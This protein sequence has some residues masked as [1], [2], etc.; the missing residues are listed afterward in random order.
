MALNLDGWVLRPARMAS[1]NFSSTG[2]ITSGVSRDTITPAEISGLGYTSVPTGAVEPWA[3]MY[4]ASTLERTSDRRYSEEY[5]LWAANTSSLSVLETDAF[6]VSGDP[7]WV[8]R[9]PGSLSVDSGIYLDGTKTFF[10]QDAGGRNLSEV[11]LIGIRKK[12]GPLTKVDYSLGVEAELSPT[13]GFVNVNPTTGKITLNQKALLD[14]E[15]GFSTARGDNVLSV[16]YILSGQRF[17]WTKNDTTATRFGWRGLASRWEAFKGSTPQALGA[18]KSSEDYKLSPPLTRFSTG[19]VLPGDPLDPDSYALIRVGVYPDSTGS[20]LVV[21]VISDSEAG[22]GNYPGSASAYDAVVGVTN[23]VLLLNPAWLTTNTGISLWYNPESYTPENTGVLG[24]LKGLPQDSTLGQPVLAPIPGPTD[25][26]L[27]RLGYRRYLTPIPVDSDSDLPVP[28]GV[29]GGEF[30]WSRSTGKIVISAEDIQKATPGETLYEIAYLGSQVYYDGVSLTQEPLTIRAATPVL[31]KDGLP[32]IGVEAGGAGIPLLG[33]LFIPRGLPLPAPGTSGVLYVPDGS[34]DK[35]NTS[36]DPQ[37]RPNGSGLSRTLVEFG[38]TFLFSASKAFENFSVKEYDDEIPVLNLKIEKTEAVSARLNP[39]SVPAGVPPEASRCDIRR[40]GLK[41]EPL[42]FLQA[43]VAPSV[44]ASEA[45]IYSR[46]TEKWI[47]TGTETLPFAIDG[48]SYL[49]DASFLAPPLNGESY[50][51]QEISDSINAVITAGAGIG[52]STVV[53]GRICLQA[54]SLSAG[55][56]EIGWNADP[57]DFSGH[58][59]LGFLPAW[60]VDLSG[61]E[62]RWLPDS[63]VSF[64]LYRSPENLDR[65]SLIADYKAVASI[66]GGLLYG[67]VLTE[68]VSGTPY[69]TINNPP[70]EDI[71][72]YDVGVHFMTVLGLNPTQLK[73]WGLNG[74]V[75]VHYE[76]DDLRFGWTQ[77]GQVPSTIIPGPTNALQLA[78]TGVLE[79]TLSSEAMAPTG[80]NYGLFLQ[81]TGAV[82][83]TELVL[84]EDFV[85]PG[86]GASGQTILVE[87]QGG[88]IFS[89][90]GGTSASGNL[91]QN[92]LFSLNATEDLILQTEL[93]SKVDVGFLLQIYNGSNKGVYTITDK[94]FSGGKTTLEVSPD[95]PLSES[96]LSWRIWEAQ[97]PDVYDPTV[98]ADVQQVPFS[99][100]AQEPWRIRILSPLGLVPT[101][102]PAVVQGALTSEREIWIRFTLEQNPVNEASASFLTRGL[103]IGEVQETGLEVPDTTSTHFVLSSVGGDAYFQIRIGERVYSTGAGNLAVVSSFTGNPNLIEVG[104]FGAGISGEIQIGANVLSDGEGEIS[105]WDEIFLDPTLLVAGEAEVDPSTGVVQI[106]SADAGSGAGLEAYFVEQLVVGANEDAQINPMNG[107][108]YLRTPLREY[109]TVE[110]EYWVA[111]SSGDKKLDSS[112]NPIL[113]V[114]YLSLTVRLETATLIDSSTY[115]FNP[116]GRTLGAVGSESIWVGP[117]LQNFAG[118]VT[119]VVNADSTISF[120]T[121][122][123]TGLTVQINYNVLE[124][125]GGEVSFS[126]SRPPVYRK[127]LFLLAEQNIFYLE[128]DRTS[129]ILPGQMLIVGPAPFYVKGVSYDAGTDQTSVEIFPT[130]TTEVGSRSPGREAGTS[131]SNLPID[132]SNGGQAGFLLSV[133]QTTNP[134][135]PVNAGNLN[136]VFVGDLIKYAKSGHILELAGIPYLIVQGTLTDGGRYTSISISTPTWT[137]HTSAD[138][139]YI[140]VRRVYA[141]NP[142]Q[143]EGISPYLS[144]EP[145]RLFLLGS[146][147]YSGMEIPGKELVEGIHYSPN[148]DTGGVSFISQNQ[149]SLEPWEKIVFSYTAL[150][151]VSPQ[152]QDGAVVYPK[153]RAQYLY[154]TFPNKTN[155]ILGSSLGAKYTFRNPDSFY[156]QV[157]PIENYLPAVAKVALGKSISLGGT[158]GGPVYMFPGTI[159]NSTQGISGLRGEV[160]NLGDQDR[161]ARAFVDFYN[162]VVVAF[163]QVL[164]TIDGRIIGDKDGKFRFFIGHDKRYAPPGWE[165]SITGDLNLRLLWRDIVNEW[166]DATFTTDNGWYDE[167][168]PVFDPTT[169]MVPDPVNHPGETDG[170]TPNPQNLSFFTQL[171]A[172]L[173]KNDMDDRILIGFG[174][175]RGLALLFPGIDVPGLFKDMWEN[176]PL[177]RLYPERTKHF[178]RLLPGIGAQSSSN[179]FTDPGYYTAG[180]KVVTPGPRVGETTKSTVKTRLTAIGAVANPALG[181]ITGIQEVTARNRYPRARVWAYYPDGSSE[182]DAALNAQI[183]LNYP[184]STLVVSTVGKATLVL[185]PLTLGSFPLDSTTG[186]PDITKLIFDTK[187]PSNP[188]TGSSYSIESGDVDLSTPKF[189]PNQMVQ[190]GKPE[191]TTYALT[192]FVGDGIFIDEVLAGCVLTLKDVSGNPLTGSSILV[193]NSQAL[194]DIVTGGTG[195]GDTLFVGVPVQNIEDIPASGDSPT[196]D[197]SAALGQSLPDYAIQKDLIV[198]KGTGQLIDASWPTYGDVFPIP[199]QNWFGQNPPKPLTCIEGEVDFSNTRRKPLQLPCLLGE[200]RDDSGDVSIPYLG[201]NETELDLLGEVASGFRILLGSDTPYPV[202]YNPPGGD[203]VLEIQNWKAIYPDE[204]VFADGTVLITASAPQDPSTLYTDQNLRPVQTSG[205]TPDT[206]IGDIRRFDLLLVEADQPLVGAGGLFAGM[207]GILSVGEALW[208]SSLTGQSTLEVPRFVTPAP[209]GGN[210]KYTLYNAWGSEFLGIFPATAGVELTDVNPAN[211]ITTLDFTDIANLFLDDGTGTLTGGVLGFLGVGGRALVI[212]VYNPDPTTPAGSEFIGAIVISDPVL[213]GFVWVWDALTSTSTTVNLAGFL[214]GVTLTAQDILSIESA[215]SVLG[216]LSG[217]TPGDKYD[218]TISLDSYFDSDTVTF[219]GGTLALGGASGSPTCEVQRDRLTFSERVSLLQAIPRGTKTANGNT[220]V[221]AKLNV[222]E[223]QTST[224][225]DCTVNSSTEI[226][227]GQDLTFLPRVGPSRDAS[228][229]IFSGLP[230]TGTFVAATGSG[231][232]NERGTIRAMSWEGHSNFPLSAQISGIKAS[233]VS[234]SDLFAS[235][236]DAILEGTGTIPDM[237]S[238]GELQTWIQNV[239]V[240]AGSGSLSNPV[241]GDILVVDG[242]S[243]GNGAVKAGTYLVRHAISN[244][245]SF[246][247]AG[248]QVSSYLLIDNAGSRTFLDL[249]FPAL[250]SF[251][252]TGLILVASGAPKVLYANSAGKRCGFPD[253]VALASNQWVYLINQNQYATWDFL[254]TTYTMIPGA[255]YRAEYSDFAYDETTG[256]VSFTLTGNYEDSTGT[257]ISAGDFET[258]ATTGKS[259]SGM[260]Y[261]PV[262]PRGTTGLPG[263]NLVGAEDILAG[264]SLTAGF[265]SVKVGNKIGHYSGGG[266]VPAGETWEKG[267][268]N[269]IQGLLNDGTSPILGRI[270]IRVP[271]PENNTAFYPD[272]DKVVYARD[273]VF[274]FLNPTDPLRGVPAHLSVHALGVT[275]WEAAHFDGASTPPVAKAVDCMLPG[276]A[277]EVEFWAVSGIFLEPSFARPVTDLSSLISP[278]VVSSS[279]TATSGLVGIRNIGDFTTSGAT[280]EDV[281]FY[282]RRIRRFHDVQANISDSLE[283]LKWGYEMRRGD[284]SS[285]TAANRNFVALVGATGAT[286]L[287]DFTNAKVNINAGDVLRILDADGNLLDQAEIQTV[288]S[289]DTLKLRRPGLDTAL[290]GTAVSFEVYLSQPLVP[291]EQSCA[292]LLDLITDS[293]VLKRT[294]DYPGGSADGGYVP[295]DFNSMKDTLITSWETAGVQEGDYVVIDPAGVLYT[296]EESGLR[297]VGDT[298]VEGR[299]AYVAGTG[300]NTLDDNRGFYR[301]GTIDTGNPDIL[302]VE[303]ASRFG[304]G[305]EDGSDDV[306]FGDSGPPDSQYAV[307][308]TIHGSPLTSPAYYNFGEREGQQALR[309]TSPPVGGSFL[310]RT[311]PGIYKSIEPFGYRII[312]PSPLFSQDAVELVLFMRE[313]MLSWIEEVKSIYQNG[314]GGDYWVFQDEDHIQDIG[315]PTDP[316]DG[317]GL[318]S[319]LVVVSLEGLVGEA[320]FANVSDCLSV[321]D[322]R[323]W[324]L[325]SR[326]DGMIPPLGTETY[327]QFATNDWEQRPVLPDLIEEVLNLQDRFRQI[328]YSWISFRADRVSGSIVTK[329]RAKSQLPEEIQKQQEYLDQKKGLDKT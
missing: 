147:D 227:G 105:Y 312:R 234:S 319:N 14:L 297:P 238:P 321:L 121:P 12:T 15:G 254:T 87:E 10:V 8:L 66:G 184:G 104:G 5:L 20:P 60:R 71:P 316:S 35:P 226:N 293:V 92:P 138:E 244:P 70:L 198:Q 80:N 328:R 310:N 33:S 108:F 56:V 63:G 215:T 143:F 157:L 77:R 120:V 266:P 322:R 68:G 26:P 186:Y 83:L 252:G 38:D 130:P 165:D 82:T 94:S 99:H 136:I 327:T 303:G 146:R 34:G 19:D 294:V 118:S 6:F 55:S 144:S 102:A 116:T 117:Q 271:S 179:G 287:G 235:S 79:E 75:G 103:R 18:A 302:P 298:S 134:L 23:G 101:L 220:D 216:S 206:G 81:K 133:D 311:A 131:L 277:F 53:R 52:S 1:G 69:F 30:Y 160:Q 194:E 262:A 139:V 50:T 178:S 111:D 207:T 27:V 48:N 93:H 219:T 202:P 137:A 203:P 229:Y 72:G 96:P 204:I 326:L 279:Y 11:T 17:W 16:S 124:A 324:I 209:L 40:R 278:H 107:S 164:E 169:G 307:L 233:A 145:Y 289:S 232:G 217:V 272:R 46:Y 135:L 62:F 295:T 317:K 98:L 201:G 242:D 305:T 44:W 318:V 230:Y 196:L 158:T 172:N 251:D 257:P 84:G 268:G 283:L 211:W 49:W 315:S 58:A 250:K 7:S 21:L 74:G 39:S 323:F 308:P 59:S 239:I 193:N 13:A 42:Y 231:A 149:S 288:V 73:N 113:I 249:S 290:L 180:R 166:A 248:V 280:S 54:P 167:K 174:R 286:N 128:T 91:F 240:G 159:D 256:E 236:T 309:P 260:Q 221:S 115:S 90:G 175:P 213:P 123:S 65:S 261:F 64:G 51:A 304:G 210:H 300:P 188:S 151:S 43:Q 285:Y 106:S 267:T 281:H 258:A 255:V 41:G 114:E 246:T 125:F 191:G 161:A 218:F 119:A 3:D 156:C 243:G 313:R 76:W 195:R 176:H 57:A 100:F 291:Q 296:P 237:Q 153:Y 89:G 2:E 86:D 110:T 259:L 142:L 306:I 325:D 253:P 171:Q 274:P 187:D 88:E 192:D 245:T 265:F 200:G 170:T 181:E 224:L 223:I 197:Q 183:A 189:E 270:G 24:N 163:E 112:G 168:D 292:Q 275:D 36:A 314:R 28:S 320:P 127:P 85:S 263:N 284:Y 212:R 148:P 67:E 129:D 190:W 185:T 228:P 45:R 9:P 152:I 132:L 37:T 154:L 182:L 205:Y 208:D 47:L 61:T 122:V 173:V 140:S 31:D 29:L 241:A 78:D 225:T 109:Q 264:T 155:R 301:V 199:L 247:S 273:Y 276:D 162:R 32:L 222:I 22:S 299:T 97:L 141:P 25:R 282:V 126:V 269:E 214:F 4:R 329:Q 95:F 177:S 150:Q